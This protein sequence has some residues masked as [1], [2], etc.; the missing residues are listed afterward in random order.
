TGYM[1]KLT[2]NGELVWKTEYGP[3]FYESYPGSRATPTIADNLLYF[4]SGRGRLVC[5]NTH[6]G[7]LVWSTHL[8]DDLN[9]ELNRY[10]FNETVV[11][12]GNKLYCTPGGRSKSVVALNRFT[13]EVIWEAEGMG[14][15]AAYCTPLIIDLPARKLLVTHTESNILGIDTN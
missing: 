13:G 10:G 2:M 8:V 9:G 3:E 15:K 14:D 12:D 5:L 4:L 1:F 11:A 6:D 7:S